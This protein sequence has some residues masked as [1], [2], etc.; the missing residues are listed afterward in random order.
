MPIEFKRGRVFTLSVEGAPYLYLGYSDKWG[1]RKRFP[2]LEEITDSAKALGAVA[3]SAEATPSADFAAMVPDTYE[4]TR[5]VLE[6][7]RLFLN[8][9]G[10]GSDWDGSGLFVQRYPARVFKF[11]LCQHVKTEEGHSPNP[12]RGW[13]PGHCSVCGMS[14]TIDSGD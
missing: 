13:H 14:M 1:Q 10:M 6:Y 4:P 12:R 7:G 11:A 5:L 9:A 2:F 8:H 3:Y